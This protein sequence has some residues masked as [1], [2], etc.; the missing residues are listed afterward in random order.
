MSLGSHYRW[1]PPQIPTGPDVLV[2]AGGGLQALRTF[3]LHAT[4]VVTGPL[5]VTAFALEAVRPFIPSHM[6]WAPHAQSE[7]NRNKGPS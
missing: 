7:A 4:V 2:T 3:L 6:R 5:L 1:L